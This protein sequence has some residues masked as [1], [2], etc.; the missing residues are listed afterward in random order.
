M[1]RC[2]PP[3]AERYVTKRAICNATIK[4]TPQQVKLVNLV[5]EHCHDIE[6]RFF[7][8]NTIILKM[9]RDLKLEN[10]QIG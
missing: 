6:M 7:A 8:K 1:S 5:K 2:V 3:S 4:I 9:K 10:H